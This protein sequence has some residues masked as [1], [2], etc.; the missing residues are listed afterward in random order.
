MTTLSAFNEIL[1]ATSYALLEFHFLPR[2]EEVYGAQWLLLKILVWG[3]VTRHRRL[4][5][6]LQ[7]I[8][9]IMS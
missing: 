8:Q 7:G 1:T 3:T 5:L 6:G 4:L 9:V 2:F